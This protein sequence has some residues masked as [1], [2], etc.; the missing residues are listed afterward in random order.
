[1][2]GTPFADGWAADAELFAAGVGAL[3]VLVALRGP[4]RDPA[5]AWWSIATLLSMTALATTLNLITFRRG[6]L[7]AAGVLLNLAVSIWLIKYATQ[8]GSLTSFVEA[9]I[10]ALSLAGVLWLLLELRARRVGGKSGSPASFHNVAALASLVA[11]ALVVAA[12]LYND[13]WQFYQT[14]SPLLDLIAIASVAAL[15]IACFWDRDAGY[16]VAGIYVL[17]LFGAATATHHLHL[18][19]R[20]LIWLLTVAVAVQAV[21]S[22]VLWRA[23]RPLLEFAG[24]L[25]IPPRLDAATDQLTWLLIFN[26]VIV[27]LI[28]ASV[29]WIDIVFDRA[30]LR[31]LASFAVLA[32]IL[33]F[34]LMAE[35]QLRR[36]LQRTAIAVFL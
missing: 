28:V 14:L 17:G 23:R 20:N 26:A 27:S 15:M 10:V 6:Y 12:H 22:A 4:F 8:T 30:M 11:M 21:V 19:P 32:Q 18:T 36:D 29:F 33:T 31:G 5:G 16:A 9:N 3:A 1:T 34:G 2:V 7:Y 25:K 35:G 24:R 13:L